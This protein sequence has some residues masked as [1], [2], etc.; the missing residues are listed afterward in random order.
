MPKKMRSCVLLPRRKEG[1]ELDG[2]ARH[3]S[4]SYEALER[5]SHLPLKHAAREIDLSPA[6][7]KKVCRRFNIE[8][9]A[10]RQGRRFNVEVP[11][12]QCCLGV[13]P[14]HRVHT[15]DAYAHAGR[16][17]DDAA[18]Q[19]GARRRDAARDGF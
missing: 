8:L 1:E 11:I 6:T 16:P 12:G 17:A 3:I 13:L 19:R 4:V 2:P 14:A 5:L 10:F 18:V 15:S 7:F 9:K